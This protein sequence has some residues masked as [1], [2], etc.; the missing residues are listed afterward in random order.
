MRLKIR[1]DSKS[2]KILQNILQLNWTQASAPFIWSP[3][4]L[5]TTLDTYILFQ[6]PKEFKQKKHG[7]AQTHSFHLRKRKY[8][9]I[10]RVVW[11]INFNVTG[12]ITKT[13]NYKQA[14]MLIQVKGIYKPM[15]SALLCQFSMSKDL[16][17]DGSRNIENPLIQV[18][19]FTN[20]WFQERR[21]LS[22]LMWAILS[23]LCSLHLCF[24]PQF[25]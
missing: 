22:I 25:Q 3:P 8:C 14:K 23:V 18:K 11:N 21:C 17:T 13:E 19:G 1:C 24:E 12:P 9:F 5:F 15:V 16:Q 7:T 6:H 4:C 2:W 10:R 20:R